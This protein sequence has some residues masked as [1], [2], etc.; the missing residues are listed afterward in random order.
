[1]SQH[2]RYSETQS[3][4]YVVKRQRRKTMAL[5]VMPDATIEIR[6][7]KWVPKREWIK[8]V[9]SRADWVI[10]QQREVL[11]KLLSQP[12]FADGEQH[13]YLGA[14]YSLN[15]VCASKPAVLLCDKGSGEQVLHVRVR[16]PQEPGAIQKALD[17]WYRVQAKQVFDTRM[18]QCFSLFSQ[19]FQE[20]Y[21]LPVITLRRMLR[22]WGSCSQSGAVTLNVQL[23]KMPLHCIDY[24]IVHELCHLLVFNHSPAF[25]Q[26][27]ASVMPDWKLRKKLLETLA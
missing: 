15:V 10:H 20:K 5:H 27:M 17:R 3:F 26:L 7:P 14:K 6:V 25:Y 24:V 23:I 2:Y 16:F 1:M 9:E 11:D 8:F 18:K 19:E 21:T 12:G 22:R 4:D 13:F